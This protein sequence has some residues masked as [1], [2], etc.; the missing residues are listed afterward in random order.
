LAA[1][2]RGSSDGAWND[3]AR[4]I[5]AWAGEDRHG[6]AQRFSRH[7]GLGELVRWMSS[8]GAEARR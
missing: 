1:A 7:C 3:A 6:W 5:E 8:N 4:R 2:Q